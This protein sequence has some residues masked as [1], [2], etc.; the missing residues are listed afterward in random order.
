M[1]TNYMYKLIEKYNKEVSVPELST[2][3]KVTEFCR[4]HLSGDF[5][6]FSGT[7]LLQHVPSPRGKVKFILLPHGF[8]L[9]PPYGHNDIF[10][11]LVDLEFGDKVIKEND[12]TFVI[13]FNK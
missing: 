6:G 9:E 4:K 1:N 12:H 2:I 10:E 5:E 7:K 13:L 3:I 8:I 11:Y